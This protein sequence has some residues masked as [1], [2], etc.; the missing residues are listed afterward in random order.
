MVLS[1]RIRE[2][3]K[4]WVEEAKRM[5][6][7]IQVNEQNVSEK[8]QMVNLT[9]RDL[10]LIK[11]LQP[12]INEHISLLVDS[13]YQTVLQIP[14]LEQMIHTYTRVDHLKHTLSQHLLELFSGEIDETFLQKRLRVAK[15]HYR[16]GLKPAWYMGAFQ[17]IQHSLFE[18]V[19]QR[20]PIKEEA[21]SFI[22]AATKLLS[23]EQQM[24]LEA[25]EIEYRS[26]QEQQYELIRQEVRGRILDISAELVALSQQTNAAV[27]TLIHNSSKMNTMVVEN[28]E[29]LGSAQSFTEEG[30]SYMNQLIDNIQTIG[31]NTKN[32]NDS[33]EKLS[34]ASSQI[35]SVIKIVQDIA[36]QTNLLALNSAIEAARAGEHGRGFAVVSD[37]VRKL[38][39]QTK[40]SVG[41]IQELV[42]NS[43]QYTE[44]VF[45]ALNKVNETV[46]MGDQ[47]SKQTSEAFSNISSSIHT[48][49]KKAMAVKEQVHHLV[50]TI[51]EI[52]QSTSGVAKSAEYLNETANM[53]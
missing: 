34:K 28:N 50:K 26:H 10:Q 15:A 39:E 49:V 3:K 18:L 19:F 6:V 37:E 53:S 48:S 32:M 29:E 12:L 36:D 20:I 21:K 30:Q 51:E 42:N 22:Q 2:E 35:T 25:Y 45:N 40:K 41:E 43:N 33:V 23:L 44:Y 8:I 38:A 52:G 17:N 46:I 7:S 9:E 1:W 11:Y 4:S 5:N 24:V 31:S 47:T 13:F 27:E 16:I 14:Q